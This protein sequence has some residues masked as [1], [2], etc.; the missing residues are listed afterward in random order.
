M[1]LLFVSVEIPSRS[2]VLVLLGCA[3]DILHSVKMAI[4][5]LDLHFGEADEFAERQIWPVIHMF[6]PDCAHNA[7]KT[8]G[9][10]NALWAS[11]L[12]YSAVPNIS[13]ECSS[14]ASGF[15]RSNFP[16]V[17]EFVICDVHMDAH[18]FRTLCLLSAQVWDEA[19]NSQ[20]SCTASGQNGFSGIKLETVTW[21]NNTTRRHNMTA[22][23]CY[24]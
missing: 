6:R 19:E 16:L 23:D 22:Q 13:S 2:L 10:F 5:Q 18:E 11:T 20:T 8:H 1:Q 4:L 21:V 12:P 7:K 3:L 24:C 17:D 14:D 9:F 15:H